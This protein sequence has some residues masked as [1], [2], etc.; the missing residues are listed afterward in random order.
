MAYRLKNPTLKHFTHLAGTPPSPFRKKKVAEETSDAS[1]DSTVQENLSKGQVA[2]DGE[3]VEYGTKKYKELYDEGS[4][5]GVSVD[6]EG[7]VNP[8][9]NLDEVVIRTNKEGD[10]IDYEKYP[11]FDELS[12]QQKEMFFD[13]GAIGRG[14]RR[15]AQTKK[16]LAGDATSMATGLL[17]NQP[18][19]ALQTP[20]SLL[21]EGIQ[22]ARGKDYNFANA[23]SPGSQRTP[24]QAFNVQNPYGALALDMIA[25]P[26]NII[27]T[28]LV[29]KGLK[30]PNL[31]K[32][33]LF[34]ST[35][36]PKPVFPGLGVGSKNFLKSNRANLYRDVNPTLQRPSEIS[37]FSYFNKSQREGIKKYVDVLSEGAPAARQARLQEIK[38]LESPEGFKRLVN[39]ELEYLKGANKG[40]GFEITT[41]NPFQPSKIKPKD[42]NKYAISNAR[43][44]I[45]ELKVPSVNEQLA[46]IKLKGKFGFFDFN[47]AQKA[48]YK[49]SAGDYFRPTKS[50]SNNA[51]ADTPVG[52]L[53]TGPLGRDASDISY[54]FRFDKPKW[55]L[56]TG[57]LDNVGGATHEIGHVLQKGMPSFIDKSL[58]QTVKSKSPK[59]LDK[60]GL[61]RTESYFRRGLG[62]PDDVS[63]YSPARITEAAPFGR[64]YVQSLQSSGLIKNRYDKITPDIIKKSIDKSGGSF[65]FSKGNRITG[66]MQNNPQ[67]RKNL[68]GILNKLPAVTAPVLGGSLIFSGDKK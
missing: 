3:K 65:S 54:R 48:L 52:G 62:S 45:K 7:N 46:K 29:A 16:G 42:F 51:F 44:R 14:I 9:F 21:V 1:N 5:A 39:Q 28:G 43:K 58:Q 19:A 12:E 27:G 38:N 66:L 13:K 31:I 47:K 17:V 4:I 25:D 53:Q 49:S 59:L 50:F 11:L 60:L 30:L 56:G 67:Q 23:L 15:R 20:Q 41:S 55:A 35:A 22:A 26:T 33:G 24:S 64:E 2:N 10:R 8:S 36:S 37:S 57:T 68:A 18:L 61:R 63:R 32:G 6:K 40:K 34:K